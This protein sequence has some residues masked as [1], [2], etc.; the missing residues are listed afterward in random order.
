MR[1][2]HKAD[3]VRLFRAILSLKNAKEANA[4]FKDL[5]TENEIE[6]LARRWKVACMLETKTPYTKII[7]ATGLSS[8]TIARAAHWMKK[9]TGGFHMIMRRKGTFLR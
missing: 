7:E 8:R 3:T 5:L 1:K 4:F 6:E 9:G 2:V